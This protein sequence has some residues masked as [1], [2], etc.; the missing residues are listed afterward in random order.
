MIRAVRAYI[1]AHGLVKPGDKIIAAV[2]GG[3]DS[4]ALL[5]ILRELSLE[6]GFTV[7]AAHVN[8]GLRPQAGSEQQFVEEKCRRLQIPCYTKSFA[9][10]ELAAG[11]GTSLEDTA[12][13]IRYGFF[14]EL[15]RELEADTIATA[16]HQDDQAETVLL[17]LLRG[18]GIQGLRGI[19]PRNGSVVRPLLQQ[20]KQSLL[21]YLDQHHIPYCV[22]QSNW[23]QSFLRNRIRH[24]LI[25]LLARD[26]N[27]QIIENLSRL[28][29]I[30]RVENEFMQEALQ[31]DWQRLICTQD[32]QELEIDLTVFKALPLAVRRRLTMTALASVGGPT[33]WEARDVEKVLDLI[34]K[35]GSAKMLRLKKGVM[36]NKSYDRMIFTSNWQNQEPFALA[37]SVPGQATLPDGAEYSFTVGDYKNFNPVPDDVYLDYDKMTLPLVLRSRRDGDVVQPVGFAGHKKLKKYLN[38]RRVPYRQRNRV[39]VLASQN[40]EIYALLGLCVCKGAAVDEHSRHILRIRKNGG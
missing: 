35:P 21:N 15:L 9:V 4:M 8:H 19:L 38:E 27:P 2:S 31:G 12:R 14:N 7:V 6:A 3:P 36:I 40:G 23:D 32:E 34:E 39:A 17:H 18:T 22:D 30:V 11:S 10:R 33:G 13:Q 25:P 1:D 16:H 28:A 29:E 24:Q 37:I 26:Y 5:Y 20:N